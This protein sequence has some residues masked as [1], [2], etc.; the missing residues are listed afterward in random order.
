MSIIQFFPPEPSHYR[1]VSGSGLM[2]T[3]TFAYGF[4][5]VP[6]NLNANQQTDVFAIDFV[7]PQNNF[8]FNAQI[9]NLNVTTVGYCLF[10]FISGGVDL[11]RIRGTS[12]AE[13]W[14]AEY[15]NGSAWV[16]MGAT[17]TDTL[18]SDQLDFHINISN[19]GWFR[20]Y[21]NRVLV[22][23]FTG[24]T[25]HT[26][27]TTINEVQIG[28]GTQGFFNWSYFLL[29]DEDTREMIVHY[30][31]SAA[32]GAVQQWAGTRTNIAQQP[33][34]SNSAKGVDFLQSG[35]PNQISTFTFQAQDA[36]YDA[37]FTVKAVILSY[38]A[39]ETGDPGLNVRAVVRKGG[40][41]YTPN[42][43]KVLDNAWT[44]YMDMFELDPSTG[45]AWAS[46]AAIEATEF[47]FQ[48]R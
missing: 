15:W 2:N 41:N 8:W 24:D 33:I 43:D 18:Q 21:L 40:T 7:S 37:G 42:P 16:Q 4:S 20:V 30:K 19:T 27:A 17:Q 47:G 38:T 39:R 44:S 22:I 46:A 13:Q 45:A 5:D 31:D 35:T 23:D 26:A 36:E 3:S 9:G 12:T 11:F 10:R 1:S 14:A 28:N 34:A 32:N 25:L 48:S 6:F 29:A